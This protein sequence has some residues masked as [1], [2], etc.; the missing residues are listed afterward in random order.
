[1]ISSSTSGRRTVTNRRL[2]MLL[3]AAILV[4]VAGWEAQQRNW[5]SAATSLS[6]VALIVALE[7][8]WGDSNVGRTK[9]A[10]FFALV[11]YVAAIAIWR[12]TGIL[13]RSA[14]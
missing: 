14:G 12:V 11:L 9:R 2:L 10:A 1:M 7:S 3:L 5:R 6:F 4:G 8:G 13:Q